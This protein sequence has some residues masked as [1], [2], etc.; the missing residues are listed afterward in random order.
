MID[1]IIGFFF[2]YYI[3]QVPILFRRRRRKRKK[4]K[5]KKKKKEKKSPSQERRGGVYF[6][7]TQSLSFRILMPKP[8]GLIEQVQ[9]QKLEIMDTHPLLSLDLLCGLF[10]GY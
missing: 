8:F 4:R 3:Y 9:H 10:P 1:E 7:D 2:F 6:S 5:K